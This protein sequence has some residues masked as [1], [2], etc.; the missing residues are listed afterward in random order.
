MSKLTLMVGLPGSG[1]SSKAAEIMKS[2][3]NTVRLNRDLLREMFHFNVWSGPKEGQTKDAARRLADFF[4]E[5]NVNVLVDDSNLNDRVVQSWKELARIHNAKIEYINM[6]TPIEECIERDS[7]REKKVGKAVILE[8]AMGAGLW[9]PDLIRSNLIIDSNKIIGI[10]CVDI[11]GT[12]ADCEH[13]KH[14]LLGEKK[15]WDGFYSEIENDPPRLNVMAQVDEYRKKGHSIVLVSGRPG[16]YRE[17]TERWLEKH[18][19]KYDVLLMR[20][21]GDKRPD[22]D[23]KKEI[24]DKCLKK[25]V[26]ECVFDDRPRIIKMWKEEGLKVFDVGNQIEF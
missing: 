12:I 3:G 17:A 6:D 7:K 11:D 21:A 16:N 4:L 8:M 26:I 2:A 1:K 18:G 25:Y 19:F 9:R 20:R 22:T 23:V 10:I 24:Y 5:N 13:R 14:Y 15:D